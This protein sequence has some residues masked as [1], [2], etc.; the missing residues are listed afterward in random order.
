MVTDIHVKVTEVKM[1]EVKVIQVDVIEVKVV[2][3]KVVQVKVNQA[4]VTAVN[5]K[6]SEWL[7]KVKIDPLSFYIAIHTTIAILRI[8]PVIA[9]IEKM[10]KILKLK[11]KFKNH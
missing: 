1:A 5:S 7:E 8:T 10:A 4:K 2:Q 6:I 3:V 9:I 11:R